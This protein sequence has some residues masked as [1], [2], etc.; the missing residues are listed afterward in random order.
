MSLYPNFVQKSNLPMPQD[1]GLKLHTKAEANKR[2]EDALSKASK[3]SEAKDTGT[4]RKR[5]YTTT[6]NG[7]DQAMIGK[8][9]AENGNASAVKHFKH[10]HPDLHESM[11]RYF[12]EWYYK[13]LSEQR[14]VRK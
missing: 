12:K 6:F 1:V 2:D 5:R 14:K 11:V 10:T 8:Y 7:E 9:A 13:V 4:S 3:A